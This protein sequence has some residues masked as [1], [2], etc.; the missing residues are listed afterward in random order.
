MP[1]SRFTESSFSP[2]SFGMANIIRSA[3]SGSDWTENDLHAYHIRVVYQDAATF[4]QIPS[5]P[6]PAVK[7]PAVL[8]LPG[9]ATAT[10]SSVYQFLRAMDL[11]MLP[12]DAGESAV[13]DFAVLLLQELGYVPVGRVLRTR[14]DIPFVICG[15]HRHAKM[16]VCIIDDV[17]I[18]LLV[19]EDKRHADGGNPVP[20]LVA[21]AI[22]AFHTNNVT[23][24]QTFGVP[25]LPSKVVPGITMKGTSPIFFKVLVSQELAMAV[26]G[27]VYPATETIVLAHLPSIP[28]PA[29]RWNEGMKPRDNRLIIMSCFEAFKQ[30]VH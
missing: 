12:V 13:D 29:D 5:L 7:H 22:A 30:F 3:K 15:E 23:R 10:D 25:P 17:G 6:P 1:P 8:T 18:L 11:A 24:E 28:R 14:K 2:T 4:F 16:D 21:K 26:M 9:P 19:Q 27:G 20:Q